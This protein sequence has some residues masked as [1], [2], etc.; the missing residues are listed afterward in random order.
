MPHELKKLEKSEM[1]LTITVAPADYQHDLEHAA[2]HMAEVAAIKG[3]RPGT[4]PYDIV[5]QQLGEQKIMET[6]LEEIVRENFYKA[7]EA[8]KLQ[9]VGM[10]VIT[11]EKLAPGNDI[12]FKAKVA[13]LPSIKLADLNKIK[14]DAKPTEIGEQELQAVLTDLRKMRMKEV[15]KDG[16][17]AK[18]DKIVVDMDMFIDKVPVEGG[19]AKGHQVYL[20]EEHYIPGFAEQLH[21]LKKDEEKEFSL[22]FPK[23][24]YQK[25]LAGK[26]VDFKVKASDVYSLELPEINDDF[27]K[28]FGQKD[29]AALQALL[30]ENLT[31]E[32]ETKESQRVEA[33]IL[34]QIVAQSEFGD[35][36]TVLITAEKQKMFNEL[37]HDLEHRGIEMEKYLL[38]IKKT[39]DEIFR[40]FAEGADKRV[41]ASLVARQVA[42]DNDIKVDKAEVDKEIEMI[43]TTYGNDP[44]VEENLK[45]P[46][47][48]DTVA[49]M[50]QNRKV[51]EF[52]KEKVVKK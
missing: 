10:P 38:D 51:V 26:N 46:E 44:K 24:H 19:Q 35:I 29:L 5:K 16:A 15:L 6:A 50:V 40:D 45:R 18:E 4:A 30:K 39:E 9:T 2:K 37:K 36:P 28:G 13:L 52:L 21:G 8:E 22:K 7:V 31:K 41:K 14:I 42:L 48:L 20:N 3:F 12:V 23:E 17:A 43:R 49:H 47:V 33:A 1:E 34:E 25:H 32:A 11:I 27:A